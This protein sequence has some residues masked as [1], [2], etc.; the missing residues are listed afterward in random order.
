MCW[1][2]FQSTKEDVFENL[3]NL[4]A[5]EFLP[6][7]FLKPSSNTRE[8][9]FGKISQVVEN[10]LRSK[11]NHGE[12]NTKTNFFNELW[13]PILVSMKKYKITQEM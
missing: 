6:L 4:I 5:H 8:N 7:A 3:K 13:P 10:N 2:R 11:N 1:S 12:E 9:I